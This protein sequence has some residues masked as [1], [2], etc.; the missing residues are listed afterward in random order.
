[1]KFRL[2]ERLV[3]AFAVLLIASL[4]CSVGSP[5]ATPAPIVIVVTATDSTDE[6]PAETPAGI[7]GSASA[8][9]NQELNI[10]GGPGTAYSVVG[11]VPGGTTVPVIGRN[12]DGSWLQ[13]THNG[14][15]GWIS[16][17]YTQTT[18]LDGV[19]VVSAPPP[20]TAVGPAPTTASGG[21]GGGA[22]T[23]PAD[24]DIVTSLNIKDDTKTFNGVI[25]FP[26]GDTSDRVYINVSGFDSIVSSGNV[27]LT[28]V[29]SGG[30]AKVSSVGNTTSGTPACNSTWVSFA[31]N[32]SNQITVRFYLDS[33]SSAYVNWTL[34]V[35]A[36]N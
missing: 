10:R 28:A 13:I 36:D 23:A 17:G 29:C 6:V 7:D 27:T 11:A 3:A 25:S 12:A 35:S 26:D 33:G 24:S 21:G 20:P 22:Q 31:G 19:Q 34:I 30:S 1:M 4:A 14:I 2:N 18:G 16:S 32:D 8:T 5:A 15:T 9:T